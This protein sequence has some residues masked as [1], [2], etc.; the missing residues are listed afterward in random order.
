MKKWEK[1]NPDWLVQLAIDQIP[2]S[3]EIIESLRSTKKA[4]Q[5]SQ[6]YIYFVDGT[7]PNQSDSEWQFE[8]NVILE[9]K[10]LGTIELKILK[11]NQVGG[12]EFLKC[13]K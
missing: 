8:E 11:N 3:I 13:I 6:A 1:Y 5:D 4:S 12:I 7:N 2:E 10:K 9:D